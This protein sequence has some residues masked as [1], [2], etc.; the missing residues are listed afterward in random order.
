MQG[1][2]EVVQQYLA[3][4]GETEAFYSFCLWSEHMPVLRNHSHSAINSETAKAQSLT[5]NPNPRPLQ[6][7]AVGP[8]AL[9]YAESAAT[10]PYTP[11][12]TARP[13]PPPQ[14]PTPLP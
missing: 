2:E 14:S 1:L 10:P 11:C 8:S 3:Q 6:L 4:E 5:T 7:W 12:Q 9:P 13:A